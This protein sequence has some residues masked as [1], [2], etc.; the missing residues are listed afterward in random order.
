MHHR[1]LEYTLKPFSILCVE[2]EVGLREMIVQ[3]LGY[4]FGTVY[5]AGDGRAAYELYTIH[6]P[7]ILLCD[8]QMP[9][10]NG[11][12]LVKK[13]RK[14]DEHTPIIMLTAFSNE[15][16]LME[17]INAGVN[18]YILKP[19]NLK[20]LDEALLKIVKLLGSPVSLG[21]DC[22]LDVQKRVLLYC[23]TPLKLRKREFDF[24]LLLSKHTNRVVRYEVI[25]ME[26]WP[27]KN[28]TMVALKSFIKE[29]RMKLP[30]N[31]IKNIPQVGYALIK[32]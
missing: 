17:L 25:E 32:K 18:H 4:Y 20:K 29:L 27:H 22:M 28:M 2:D 10:L 5:E 9:H 12:D 14:Q 16:E 19:L 30:A 11:I 23:G 24:L 13:I 26:L 3:T 6:K 21:C 7:D 1:A 15:G 8:I 31:L